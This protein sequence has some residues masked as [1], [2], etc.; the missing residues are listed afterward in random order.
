[1]FSIKTSSGIFEY[2][3][4]PI[5]NLVAA[6][7]Q[8][9]PN[10]KGDAMMKIIDNQANYRMV[11]NKENI[12]SIVESVIQEFMHNEFRGANNMDDS[13]EITPD[14]NLGEFSPLEL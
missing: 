7:R 8:K 11:E 3:A 9:F 1:M 6:L 4:N 10:M 12:K 13:V 14:M 2:P 5:E